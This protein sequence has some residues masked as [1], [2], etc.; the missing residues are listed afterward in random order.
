MEHK[1]VVLNDSG[2]PFLNFVLVIQQRGYSSISSSWYGARAE[3]YDD[4]WRQLAPVLC[5]A[6]AC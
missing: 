3:Y 1:D 4:V 5:A 6:S 2:P